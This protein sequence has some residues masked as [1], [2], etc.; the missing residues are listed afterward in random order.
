[1]FETQV[2][3][4][5]V[6]MK[7]SKQENNVRNSLDGSKECKKFIR[8]VSHGAGYYILLLSLN[9]DFRYPVNK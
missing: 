5:K 1:M 8:K 6:A 9:E 4:G 2:G 3:R 7:E